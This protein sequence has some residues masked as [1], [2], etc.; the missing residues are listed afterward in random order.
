MEEQNE[1]SI[2]ENNT[3]VPETVSPDQ[4]VTIRTPFRRFLR[5]LLVV[6]III[7]VIFFILCVP[8]YIAPA[9]QTSWGVSRSEC[10][11]DSSLL[12]NKTIKKQITKLDGD[13]ER[14]ERK[15][16]GLIP[17]QSYLVIN[18][19]DNKFFLYKNRKLIRTGRC[20]SGKNMLL[21]SPDGKETW[22]FKT[23]R[24]CFSIQG[25]TD[26]PVWTKPDWAFVEEGLPIPKKGD[27]SRYERNVL[28]DYAM[29]LGHG[30]MIHGT[31]YK[32]QIGMPV[33]H[34]CVRLN[35]EDLEVVVK[36]MN[37]GSKVY[38]Y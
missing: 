33:T 26:N 25:K 29:M 20:S 28:G 1:N 10:R 30:Y 19:V 27:P 5:S 13:I 9:F 6:T 21:T 7:A 18:T 11:P 2:P 36:T 22:K 38:I 32:R 34:G 37:V 16:S 12:K 14:L 4:G 17:T 35:D 8:V 15:L 23:P 31:I 24:G 3:T